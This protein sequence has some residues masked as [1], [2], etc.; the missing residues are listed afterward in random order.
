MTGLRREARLPARVEETMSHTRSGVHAPQ[1]FLY[2]LPLP[3][4]HGSFLPVFGMA[5]L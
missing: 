3:H 2:F 5:F 1:N 4:G